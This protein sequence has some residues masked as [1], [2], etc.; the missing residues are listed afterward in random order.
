MHPPIN[1]KYLAAVASMRGD[2]RRHLPVLF[3]WMAIETLV[4]PRQCA[5]DDFKVI[6]AG[7]ESAASIA[8]D[9]LCA[10]GWRDHGIPGNLEGMSICLVPPS[11]S[12]D[13][14][15]LADDD[16]SLRNDR[17]MV[18]EPARSQDLDSTTHKVALATPNT[19]ALDVLRALAERQK[20]RPYGD[21]SKTQDFLREARSG[22]MYSDGD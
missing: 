1:G 8:R 7:D 13:Y 10:Q 17:P 9:M 5:L 20:D 15:S 21:S 19:K 18:Q 22:R 16:S 2:V 4:P 6:R 14:P 11:F 3:I 12:E